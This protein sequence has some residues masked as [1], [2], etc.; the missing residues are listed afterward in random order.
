MD[1]PENILKNGTF[2]LLYFL[3]SFITTTVFPIKYPKIHTIRLD[4]NKPVWYHSEYKECG[5]LRYFR[6]RSETGRENIYFTKKF[7][8]TMRRI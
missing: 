8:W 7:S 5:N 4:K 6:R 3:Y 2:L 1:T